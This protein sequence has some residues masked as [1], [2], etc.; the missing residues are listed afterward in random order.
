MALEEDRGIEGC[1]ARSTQVQKVDIEIIA[2]KVSKVD[3]YGVARQ[4]GEKLAI[5]EPAT[6]KQHDVAVGNPEK[7]CRT[8]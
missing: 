8:V 7:R 4:N 5:T 3:F 6:S 1:T 2:F